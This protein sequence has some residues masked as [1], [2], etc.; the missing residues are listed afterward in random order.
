MSET[1]SAQDQKFGTLIIEPTE[2]P[3]LGIE[4]GCRCTCGQF[5]DFKVESSLPSSDKARLLLTVVMAHSCESS[6]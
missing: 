6:V 1:N 4:M 2:G 3:P 5:L